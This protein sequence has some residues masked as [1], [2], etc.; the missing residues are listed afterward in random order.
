M[1]Q[2]K[3]LRY[4]KGI[5]IRVNDAGDIIL[6]NAEDN[7]FIKQFYGL[8]EKIDQISSELSLAKVGSDMEALNL[9]IEKTREIMA[10][11]DGLFGENACFKI[12][13]NAVP[14]PYAI[15]DF[16]EQMSPIIMEYADDRQKKIAEKYNVSRK[17][18]RQ[19]YRSKEEIIQ[20]A[21]R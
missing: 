7:L 20:D 5:E 17:G 14:T 1:D 6:V 18:S 12:F 15:A 19:K 10:D 11:I 9:L 4:R 3:D 8:T 13:G 2:I 21:M 16:F